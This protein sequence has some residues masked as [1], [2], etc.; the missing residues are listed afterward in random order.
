MK[1]RGVVAARGS[2]WTHAERA[3]DMATSALARS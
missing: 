3:I 2:F 1:R